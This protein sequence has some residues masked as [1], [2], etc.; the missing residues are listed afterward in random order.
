MEAVEVH[1]SQRARRWRLEAPW[2]RP[3]RL[4]VPRTMSEGEIERVLAQQE[5]W[6]ARERRRQV[7]RLGLERLAVS[8]SEARIAAR[9]LIS[10]LAEEEAERIGVSYQRLRIG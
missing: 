5:G 2:G 4:T 7:P 10:A 9:E 8:G 6:L 3:A 1:R